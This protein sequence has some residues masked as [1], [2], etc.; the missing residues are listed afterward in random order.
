MASHRLY[1][2][3][4]DFWTSS[5]ESSEEESSGDEGV[6]ISRGVPRVSDALALVYQELIGGNTQELEGNDSCEFIEGRGEIPEAT[7][8]APTKR[9]IRKT[10]VIHDTQSTD[11]F[12]AEILDLALE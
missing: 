7:L 1:G 9:S 10:W 6:D 4:E 12:A 2:N 8:I 5:G 3:D 11:N